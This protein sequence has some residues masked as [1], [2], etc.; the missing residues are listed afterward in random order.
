MKRTLLVLMMFSLLAGFAMAES[1]DYRNQDNLKSL[2]D[3]DRSDFL[4]LDVRT[5]EEFSAGH[6]PESVNIPYDTLPGALPGNTAKD[7]LI[8]VY[9]RSGNRSGIA[10]RA[11][12]KA[13]YTNIQD[14]GGIS[15]WKGQLEK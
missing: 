6:I 14:F 11:L 15:R 2:L 7:Q 4:L 13:G 5:P 8:I 3:S 12:K 9:C 1:S 10:A